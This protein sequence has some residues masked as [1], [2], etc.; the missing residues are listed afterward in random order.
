MWEKNAENSILQ[1]GKRIRAV[2]AVRDFLCLGDWSF[3]R[4]FGLGGFGGI[5]GKSKGKLIV[6]FQQLQ[7]DVLHTSWTSQTK[8][9]CSLLRPFD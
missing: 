1:V 9:S 5:S 2:S 7:P 6:Q 4:G 3:V 8:Y